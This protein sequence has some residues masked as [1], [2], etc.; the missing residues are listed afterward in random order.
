MDKLDKDYNI[1]QARGQ[2]IDQARGQVIDPNIDQNKCKPND[3]SKNRNKGR[4][5]RKMRH[6]VI[7]ALSLGI[8][9]AAAV[10][11]VISCNYLSYTNVNLDDM[12]QVSLSGYNGKG[13]VKANVTSPVQFAD[14]AKTVK[15]VPDKNTDLKNGDSITI[16]WEYDKAEAKA[17]KLR[18]QADPV[19]YEISGL[20]D[21][22][23][24]DND[25]L[26]K[27]ISV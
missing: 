24:I 17:Q 4:I 23:I 20:K 18:V 22:R 16:T 21:A 14:F 10:I 6:R 11:A 15:A 19:T 9:V 3:Q 5:T 13:S 7:I 27:D 25:E 2:D 8:L 1:D 12:L 26:F